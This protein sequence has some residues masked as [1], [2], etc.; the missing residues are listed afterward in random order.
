MIAPLFSAYPER[1]NV[2]DETLRNPYQYFGTV[3]ALGLSAD[4]A[5]LKA[6]LDSYLNSRLLGSGFKF[7]LSDP[8]NPT[9]IMVVSDFY[10]I[11]GYP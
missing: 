8:T 6:F 5:I 9:V 2:A 3:R 7:D 10:R 4:A 11:T 1:S